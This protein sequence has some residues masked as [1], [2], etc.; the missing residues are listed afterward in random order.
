MTARVKEGSGP[1]G[2]RFSRRELLR[3]WILQFVGPAMI[4]M[5]GATW[6]TR[7]VNFEAVERVHAE[8]GAVV[9]GFW[10]AH[11]LPLGYVYRG[12][13]VFVLTS[14]HR[15]GEMG[16]RLMTGLGYGVERGSTSRG[17]V[18]GLLKMVARGRNGY[19][20]AITPDGPR[21]PARRAQTGI[22]YLAAK[23]GGVVIPAAVAVS[24]YRRLSSWDGFLIPLPFSRVIVV[25]GEPFEQVG[26]DPEG[27]NLEAKAGR[28]GLELDR[29]AELALGMLRREFGRSPGFRLYRG[30]A[31]LLWWVA[32]PWSVL[33]RSLGRE[34]WRERLGRAPRIPPG[35]LWIHVASVGEITAVLPLVRALV[36]RGECVVVTAVTRTGVEVARSLL[37][38]VCQVSFAPLDF[39]AAVSSTLSRMQP[40]A[41]ILA[42]TE[43][44]PNLLAIAEHARLPVAVVNGRLSERTVGRSGGLLS[45]LK[46]AGGVLALAA[47]QTEADRDRFLRLGASQG[48]VHVVGNLKFDTL[49]RPLSDSERRDMRASL[50]MEQDEMV[51]VF[52]SVR[53]KE[54]RG[55]VEVLD[56]LLR[57]IP[58]LRAVVAPRHLARVA[59]LEKKLAE[60]GIATV[61]RTRLGAASESEKRDVVLLDTTGDLS[62]LYAVGDVAFVGGS[63]EA[64]GG[65]NPLEPAA[66]HVPVLLGPY[67]DSCR[68]SAQELLDSGAAREV[69]DYGEL[70]SELRTLLSDPHALSSMKSAAARALA[71]GRGATASTIELLEAG[72]ILISE[73]ERSDS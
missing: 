30:F 62:S 6:R 27:V 34:E 56:D 65:H 10:H 36:Y 7:V 73:A 39:P 38:D 22:L 21:G 46:G 50:G 69:Q 43:L 28:L 59:T 33:T 41:L 25:H 68:E 1:V 5:L 44:W 67:T 17:S 35:S 54:E 60:A 71:S 42:E 52:G 58:G 26:P 37:G 29:L 55:I 3:M 4:R 16:A 19:D 48:V 63:L 23:S 14:W 49:A 20:L 2:A 13:R 8:G 66:Q 11:I 64:Y 31:I 70:A 12:R 47:V 9:H 45:P 18:R 72:G 61:R 53:P 15:D 51:V 32:L 24:R 40:R 57:E